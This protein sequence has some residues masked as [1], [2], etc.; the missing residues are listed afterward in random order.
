MHPKS[1]VA[2][3][4]LL[5]IAIPVQAMAVAV[6]VHCAP[7]HVG[8]AQDRAKLADHHDGIAVS[9]THGP[10]S[11]EAKVHAHSEIGL[12]DNGAVD[13]TNLAKCSA[14]AS[15]CVGA[16]LPVSP[17]PMA[18]APSHHSPMLSPAESV[19]EI[20]VP[21]PERPPRFSLV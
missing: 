15:C 1:V 12:V 19:L 6:K 4:W 5:I 21:G 8:S 3:I 11:S 16:A 14:C 10:G 7:G 18:V 13:L 17:R 20:F 9:Y 2:L